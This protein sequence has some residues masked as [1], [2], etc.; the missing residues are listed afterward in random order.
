MDVHDAVLKQVF[1]VLAE[2]L[3]KVFVG[4]ILVKAISHSIML[5]VDINSDNVCLLGKVD[6]QDEVLVSGRISFTLMI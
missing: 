2:V 1:S 5:V 3:S 4:K 6:L